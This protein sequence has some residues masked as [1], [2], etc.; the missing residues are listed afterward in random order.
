[1]HATQAPG[2]ANAP[3][4]YSSSRSE[5][6]IIYLMYLK[7][8]TYD[9]VLPPIKDPRTH[10]GTTAGPSFMSHSFASSPIHDPTHVPLPVSSDADLCHGP[11]V[12]AA[13]GHTP[14]TKVSGSRRK[15][16]PNDQKG[17]GKRK[18]DVSDLDSCSSGED[19][20]P[21]KVKGS[22]GG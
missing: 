15:V 1:M 9:L 22:H 17:K 4:V 11:T 7:G 5:S 6:I 3:S 14:T 18:L 19:S 13:T 12:A 8:L 21:T 16:I 20:E 10:T 2:F